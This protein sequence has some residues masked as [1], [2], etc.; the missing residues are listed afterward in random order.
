MQNIV[1]VGASL[2]GLRAA[3]ALRK[4]GYSGR[5]SLVGDE[6]HLPYDRPP[7]SKQLLTGEWDQ[8]RVFFRQKEGFAGLDL[9]LALGRRAQSLDPRARRVTLDDGSTLDYDGLVIATG[10]R[11]RRLTL[12]AG[13][14]GI[15]VL[16]TLDDSL[17]ISAALA[18]RPR[19]LVVGAGWIGLEVAAACRKLGL[20]VVVIETEAAPLARS[21]GT[22]VGAALVELH[23]ARGVDLR[24]STA[25][26]ALEGLT[27][28]E[29]ARLSD[30]SALEV[31]L[32]VAGIGV[33][34]EIA[35]LAGSGLTLGNGVICDAHCATNVPD[36][37]AAGDVAC[38]ANTLF[39][40]TLRIEHW[41]NAIEQAQL[42]AGRLLGDVSPPRALG[43]VPYFWSDQYDLK[44]Q[45][46]GRVR[47]DDE[48]TLIEGTLDAP[49]YVA[50]FGRAGALTG[51]L[52]CNRPA[53][54]IKY[55]RA[56]AERTTLAAALHAMQAADPT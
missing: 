2:G 11:A 54:M 51:V 49:A 7:L 32:V 48:L 1:I 14:S 35:W 46:A 28:V 6:P 21:L 55:R 9:Q 15:H 40:D 29:R 44:F 5:L 12:G 42:A 10:A 47:A 50:L 18:Q 37:V 20:S 4:R 25:L 26:T 19:V 3:E 52:A 16:R 45:C 23:R 30:G 34:P 56:I 17:A 27:R 8:S 24:L 41:A 31:D 53:A 43:Q 38:A 13:L 39:D 36:V 33:V 22:R